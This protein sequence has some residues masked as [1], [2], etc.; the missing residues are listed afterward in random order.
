MHVSCVTVPKSSQPNLNIINHKNATVAFLHDTVTTATM[1]SLKL[2]S[3]P[4]P[5]LAVLA[6]IGALWAGSK[7][8]SY[9][10]LLL[11]LFVLSGKNVRPK[12][13]STSPKLTLAD[14]LIYS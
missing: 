8:V 6:A 2:D 13:S 5:L 3:I 10:R 7:V 1:Q 11:S 12:Q 9:A 4:A 14:V